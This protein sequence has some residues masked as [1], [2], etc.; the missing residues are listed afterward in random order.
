MEGSRQE[1]RDGTL[2]VRTRR[3][4]E[5]CTLALA[6]ELDMANAKTLEAQLEEAERAG[7]SVIVLDMRDLEFIDST[8]IALL[9]ATHHRLNEGDERF[10]LVPSEAQGVSR[11]MSVTGIDATLPSGPPDEAEGTGAPGRAS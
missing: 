8:G 6:G 2:V 4:A 10:L 7:A 9:V 1:V 5:R 11:V 3:E